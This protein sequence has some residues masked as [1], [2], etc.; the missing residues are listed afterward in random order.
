MKTV[1]SKKPFA[2]YIS[3]YYLQSNEGFMKVLNG[4]ISTGEF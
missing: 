3:K 4:N 1:E 2:M